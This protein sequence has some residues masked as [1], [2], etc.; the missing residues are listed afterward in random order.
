MEHETNNVNNKIF[1]TMMTSQRNTEHYRAPQVSWL[2]V[3]IHNVRV[4]LMIGL[5]IFKILLVFPLIYFLILWIK[6]PRF[7]F[8]D[9]NIVQ[10]FTVVQS[11]NIGQESLCSS[12]IGLGVVPQSVPE[13]G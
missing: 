6:S 12:T 10:D 11:K 4:H 13:N 9:S 8:Y 3:K 5:N 7:L 2:G 1:F